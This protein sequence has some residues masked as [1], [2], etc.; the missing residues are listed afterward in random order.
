M[1]AE[2]WEGFRG[3]GLGF[4]AFVDLGGGGLKPQ[5]PP[6]PPNALNPKP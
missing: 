6:P 3:S 4:E 2:P 5:H 1:F